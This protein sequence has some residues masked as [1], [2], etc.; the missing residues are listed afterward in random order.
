MAR[1]KGSKLTEEHKRRISEAHK[2]KIISEET[3]AKLRIISLGKNL[4]EEAK[5]RISNSLRLQHKGGL[6][7]DAY[8][9][10]S[11]SK[12]GHPVSQEARDKISLA[13]KGKRYE[14]FMDLETANKRKEQLRNKWLGKNNP[15]WINGE[16][17]DYDY[18][19]FNEKFK[20]L[21]R[22][23]DNQICMNCLIHREKINKSLDVHHIDYNERNTIPQNCISLCR[24]CHGL[25]Q[26]N[27]EHWKLF[28]QN[29]LTKKY[30]YEY[31]FNEEIVII[32]G[33]YK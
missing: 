31:K 30:N 14:D 1:H 25:T 28:F 20:K 22:K 19:K 27:R 23:R 9:K 17:L 4:T 24:K 18:K 32:G 15:A 29:L 5:Q 13:F 16:L 6:R 33:K 8:K 26:F 12:L 10:I 3:K 7:K 21:I 11:I 2:G